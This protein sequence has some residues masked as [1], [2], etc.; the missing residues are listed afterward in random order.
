M[1]S[2]QGKVHDS[3]KFK[4][5][6]E[7]CIVKTA[8]FL[9]EVCIFDFLCKIRSRKW[10][11]SPLC[12]FPNKYCLTSRLLSLAFVKISIANVLPCNV[13]LPKNSKL[14][15]NWYWKR[16]LTFLRHI[17]SFLGGWGFPNRT[18][19]YTSAVTVDLRSSAFSPKRILKYTKKK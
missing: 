13:L 3:S 4:I 10:R 2:D 18:I 16:A 7:E 19:F 11:L 9:L 14:R 1:L 6:S 15:R 5:H 12:P 17:Y 8:W